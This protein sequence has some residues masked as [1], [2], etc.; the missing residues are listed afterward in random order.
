MI[1][2]LTLC[3]SLLATNALWAQHVDTALRDQFLDGVGQTE[4]KVAQLSVRVRCEYTRGFEWVSDEVAATLKRANQNPLEKE[5]RSYEV[6]IQGASTAMSGASGRDL[7]SVLAKNDDY[8]FH[9]DRSGA[10]NRY[11]LRFLEWNGEDPSAD[12]RIREMDAQARLLPLCTWYV[13]GH[14]I[15]H[16]VNSPLFDI[17]SISLMK[18]D[19]SRGSGLV[20][21]DFEHL[22]DDPARRAEESL[23]NGYLV[24]DP[25][26]GWALREYCATLASGVVY[27]VE[28]EFGNSVEGF[29]IPKEMIRTTTKEGVSSR[30]M[31]A[32]FQLVNTSISDDEFHLRHYGLPEPTFRRGWLG[33]WVWYLLAAV[34]CIGASLFLLRRRS[35]RG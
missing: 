3:F 30:R 28:I 22:V 27:H 21:V 6:V 10:V 19:D 26:R 7:K 17:K 16:F 2:R 5:T 24:C 25:S 31:V 1:L 4:K 35:N 15:S 12:R 11:T 13:V 20:R 9:I 34:T 32:K 8:A 29:P 23:S 18:S 14:T 33:A